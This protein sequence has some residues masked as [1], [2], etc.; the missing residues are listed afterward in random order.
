MKENSKK[1]LELNSDIFDKIN[2]DKLQGLDAHLIYSVPEV[3]I[4]IVSTFF[5]NS[6]QKAQE[7]ILIQQFNKFLNKN[8]N[9][10]LY[11]SENTL[12]ITVFRN[13][14]LIFNNSFKFSTKEDILYFTLF[15]FEQLK[16]NTETVIV[17]VYG[18]IKKIDDNYKLLYEYIRN[19]EL[20]SK[21]D[22]LNLSQEFNELQDHE[23]YALFSQSI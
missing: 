5:P 1:T 10:Y 7:T 14:K 11:L 15:T 18:E 21:V 20:G 13:G 17:K 2:T 23:F 6:T 22:Y 16:L 9:A 19:I 3:I 4:E 8:D 12:N